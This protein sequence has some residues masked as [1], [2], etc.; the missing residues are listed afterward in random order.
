MIINR[1]HRCIDKGN[2]SFAW[3]IK[4]NEFFIFLHRHPAPR[5]ARTCTCILLTGGQCVFDYQLCHGH[6]LCSDHS[7]AQYCKDSHQQMCKDTSSYVPCSGN[8]SSGHQECYWSSLSFER[9]MVYH[10]L[11]RSDENVKK[12]E[13]AAIEFTNIDYD[14]MRHCYNDDGDFIGLIC[15]DRCLSFYVWCNSNYFRPSPPPCIT[16]SSFFKWNN[17]TL[18]K[19]TTFWENYSC[20][21]KKD[22]KVIALGQRCRGRIQQCYILPHTTVSNL[23]FTN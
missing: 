3:I 21:D 22:D 17:P 5:W 7:D 18:C 11:T 14:S 9:D 4:K 10:C 20:D 1:A 23:D 2:P 6:S 15:G 19:N 16:N 13:I 12:T 8:I